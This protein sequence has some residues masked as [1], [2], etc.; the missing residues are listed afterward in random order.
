MHHIN[1]ELAKARIADLH[2][3]A[4]RDALARAARRARRA[5]PHQSGHPVPAFPFGRRVLAML[6]ARST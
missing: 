6:G 1:Y 3:Q 2:H 4:Q 5:R